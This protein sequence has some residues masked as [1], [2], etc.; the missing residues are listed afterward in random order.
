MTCPKCSGLM[1]A[2]ACRAEDGN[3]MY[4]RCIP[5]SKYIFQVEPKTRCSVVGCKKEATNRS[6]MCEVHDD[7]FKYR[8]VESQTRAS[9]EWSKE[10]KAKLSAR[11]A[12][13]R[14]STGGSNGKTLSVRT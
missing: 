12:Q 13:R 6:V 1:V 7:K 11:L 5:C 9:G 3:V 4:L 8:G 10:A 2:E 14:N